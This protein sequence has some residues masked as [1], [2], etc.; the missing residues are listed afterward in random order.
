MFFNFLLINFICEILYIKICFAGG[1]VPGTNNSHWHDYQWYGLSHT[2]TPVSGG[3]GMTFLFHI[4]S[5]YLLYVFLLRFAFFLPYLFL[6]TLFPFPF[7][8]T[9]RD[10]FVY[11]FSLYTYIYMYSFSLP[12]PFPYYL[13]LFLFHILTLHTYL[14]MYLYMY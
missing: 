6:S 5:T 4:F 7:P 1:C 8:P 10:L 3:A 9:L 13:L 14:Y 11:S 2:G 12:F